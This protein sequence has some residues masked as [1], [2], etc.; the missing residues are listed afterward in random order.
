MTPAPELDVSARLDIADLLVQYAT[1][2]DRRLVRT[3]HGWQIR[4]RRFTSVLLQAIGPTA[5]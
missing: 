5:T 2:I 4:S 1:G 3:E